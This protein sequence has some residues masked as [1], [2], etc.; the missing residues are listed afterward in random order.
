MRPWC[1]AALV[2]L[3]LVVAPAHAVAQQPPGAITPPDLAR[4]AGS[5]TVTA[6][7]GK[8]LPAQTWTRQSSELTC[9]SV[10]QEGTLLLDSRGRWALQVT[11]LDRCTGRSG[12]REILP[13]MS[14]ISTGTY[15][16]AGDSIQF[17]NA[18]TGDTFTGVLRNNV[19]TVTIAGTGDLDGQRVTY[20]ARRERPARTR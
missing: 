12:R 9:N 11:E 14:A 6:V 10:T 4:V 2:G 13:E 17:R 3:R 19:L 1:I 20:A 15:T 5:F 16:V 7:N 8:A 18:E